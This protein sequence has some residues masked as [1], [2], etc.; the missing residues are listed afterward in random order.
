MKEKAKQLLNLQLKI[1]YHSSFDEPLQRKKIL[2]DL[3]E[4]EKFQKRYNKVIDFRK[5]ITNPEIRPF[6]EA[7]LLDADQEQHLFRQMNYLKYQAK[8]LI[9]GI[10]LNHISKK[11]IAEIEKYLSSAVKIRNL[12]AECNFR[13]VIQ[14][15]KQK[16]LHDKDDVLSDAYLDVLRSV[17]YFDYTKGNKFS[18]YATWVLKKNFFRTLKKTPIQ[19]ETLEDFHIEKLQYQEDIVDDKQQ[20][21]KKLLTL[22]SDKSPT[23]DNLRQLFVL[24]NYFGVNGKEKITLGKISEEIGVTKERARQ[25]K[26]KGLL[27]IKNK[28]EELDLQVEFC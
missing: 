28:I 1:F 3:P 25:L 4:I 2:A 20:L 6:Y 15:L 9:S 8:K 7:P 14:I 26:D 17:D 27:W 12:I 21:V 24:E 16:Y 18:T 13:L 22:L 19:N 5:K 23:K 10:N 11:R